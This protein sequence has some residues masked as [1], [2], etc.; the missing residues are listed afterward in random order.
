MS[1]ER[2]RQYEKLKADFPNLYKTI[3]PGNFSIL[4]G[5][6]P[7]VH[8]LSHDLAK[9]PIQVVQVK[10]K[11][12]G[13]RFYIDLAED[14]DHWGVIGPTAFEDVHNLISEAEARSYKVCELCGAESGYGQIRG[15]WIKT[16]CAGCD[17]GAPYRQEVSGG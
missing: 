11:F 15:N 10:E 14:I 16:S 13:L 6:M 2:Q 8:H 3:R 4:V 7:L 9:Y 17:W 1:S 5:W 12:G